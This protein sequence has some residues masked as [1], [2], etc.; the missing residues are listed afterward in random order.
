MDDWLLTLFSNYSLNWCLLGRKI[1]QRNIII[2][3][4]LNLLCWNTHTQWME[5]SID[6]TNK[7]DLVNNWVLHFYWFLL[8]FKSNLKSNL[9]RTTVWSKINICYK[10]SSRNCNKRQKGYNNFTTLIEIV[11]VIKTKVKVIIAK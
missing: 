6:G 3:H 9:K 11:L 7:S 4:H 1:K 8:I 2:Q 10:A 5:T